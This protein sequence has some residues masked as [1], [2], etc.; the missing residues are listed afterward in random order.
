MD[1]LAKRWGRGEGASAMRDVVFV[2]CTFGFFVVA[3][4]YVW[5]CERLK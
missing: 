2:A 4:V 3:I 1:R 5:A